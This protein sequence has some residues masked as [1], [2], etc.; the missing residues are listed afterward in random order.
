LEIADLRTRKPRRDRAAESGI[1]VDPSTGLRERLETPEEITRAK[2]AA[3]EKYATDLKNYTETINSKRAA[4]VELQVRRFA[5]ALKA[6]IL[7]EKLEDIA[8]GTVIDPVI[9]AIEFTEKQIE[10]A[11]DA[12]LKVIDKIDAFVGA[13]PISV[14]ATSVSFSFTLKNPRPWSEV[15]DGLEDTVSANALQ[16]YLDKID[17]SKEALMNSQFASIWTLTVNALNTAV[18]LFNNPAS[19]IRTALVPV[20]AF[21]TYK[22]LLPINLSW[23]GIPATPVSPIGFIQPH[24]VSTG[25]KSFGI[26]GFK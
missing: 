16:P 19:P 12:L 26:P 10:K 13:L 1:R 20:E 11:F 7:S 15:K 5:L 4:K 23:W 24:F 3:L 25:G 22:A 8:T 21:P 14:D 2:A 17:I 6:K 18:G 9:Q